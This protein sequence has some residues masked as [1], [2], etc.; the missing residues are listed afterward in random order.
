MKLPVV[1]GVDSGTSATKVIACDRSG[2]TLAEATTSHEI[3]SDS[4]GRVEQDAELWWLALAR[5]CRAVMQELKPLK[6]SVQGIGLT[7]QR[8]SFCPS[9]QRNA[10]A[11]ASDP[12]ERHQVFFGS[13]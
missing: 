2:N 12:L 3:H 5:G 7:H 8:F 11:P 6:V 1:L 10:S 4:P 13:Q 9:R